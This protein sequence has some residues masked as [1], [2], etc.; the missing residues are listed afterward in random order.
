MPDLSPE[1]THAEA[2][3]YGK[4]LG[5]RMVLDELEKHRPRGPLV[6]RR[7]GET[8]RDAKVRGDGMRIGYDDAVRVVRLT[9]LGVDK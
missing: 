4:L 6:V 3:A 5:V 2:V 9:R 1:R 8:E 7:M